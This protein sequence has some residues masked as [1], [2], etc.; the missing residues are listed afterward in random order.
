M[1]RED[2]KTETVLCPELHDPYTHVVLEG[3]A[4]L[5]LFSACQALTLPSGTY[6]VTHKRCRAVIAEHLGSCPKGAPCDGTTTGVHA[7]LGIEAVEH[8]RKHEGGIT[9]GDRTHLLIK[10]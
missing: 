9:R 3:M 7:W 6:G 1:T 10:R 5:T 4:W 8:H 2:P